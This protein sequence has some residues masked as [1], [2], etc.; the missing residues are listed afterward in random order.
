MKSQQEAA[1]R[2]LDLK[3]KIK[4]HAQK[5]YSE[6][7]QGHFYDNMRYRDMDEWQLMELSLLMAICVNMRQQLDELKKFKENAMSKHF[8]HE[9]SHFVTVKKNSK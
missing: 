4:E 9:S 5:I 1:Q 8:K 7:Y 2:R 3:K 6:K